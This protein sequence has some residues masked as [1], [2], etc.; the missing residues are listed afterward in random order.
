M[1]LSNLSL[2]TDT[3]SLATASD[4]CDPLDDNH[5]LD[6]EDQTDER[7]F[8]QN[9]AGTCRVDNKITPSGIFWIRPITIDQQQDRFDFKK[10]SNLIGNFITKT[11]FKSFS[12][13]HIVPEANKKC[14]FR[15]RENEWRRGLIESVNQE[16]CRV[17]DLDFGSFKRVLFDDIYPHRRLSTTDEFRIPKYLAI[18]C[19]LSRDKVRLDG[20]QR[21]LFERAAG[22]GTGKENFKTFDLV[23]QVTVGEKKCWYTVLVDRAGSMATVNEDVLRGRR[24]AQSM[25]NDVI[26]KLRIREEETGVAAEAVSLQHQKFSQEGVVA[27]SELLGRENLFRSLL[28]Q[29]GMVQNIQLPSQACSMPPAM[30]PNYRG[31]D[32]GRKKKKVRKTHRYEG[33][34]GSWKILVFDVYNIKGLV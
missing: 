31:T 5:N 24:M 10:L 4:H 8:Y 19:A 9:R 6:L 16:D 34:L 22:I 15:D 25:S 11:Q 33:V 14:F 21:A 13:L 32:D 7:R 1:V 20:Q 28:I 3:P 12:E 30:H 23:E 17:R 18:R 26:T 27:K 29:Q 2:P